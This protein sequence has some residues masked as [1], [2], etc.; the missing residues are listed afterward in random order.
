M[1]KFGIIGLVSSS[2]CYPFRLIEL[3]CRHELYKCVSSLQL[4]YCRS[5]KLF[6]CLSKADVVNFVF[7]LCAHIVLGFLVHCLNVSTD[8][9][10]RF[11]A[12]LT[13]LV[14]QSV[15]IILFVIR[16][17]AALFTVNLPA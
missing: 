6:A 16:L 13:Q 9:W 5:S 15:W 8:P 4:N 17:I 7:N 12:D 11:T 2:S 14:L 10:H 3:D 1:V